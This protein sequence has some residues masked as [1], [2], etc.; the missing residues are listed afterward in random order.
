[1]RKRI[2]FIESGLTETEQKIVEQG[3][4]QLSETKGAPEYKKQNLKWVLYDDRILQGALT[5]ST[6][7]D[8]LY[9]D[10]LWVSEAERGQGLGKALLDEAERFATEN[11]LSG[12]WLWTQSWQA[13]EFYKKQGFLEFARFENFPKG[14][15]RIGLRK[16][17]NGD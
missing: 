9:I 13:E 8:W 10:E 16:E 15:Q 12:L 14:H 6:L 2:K 1:M 17:L 4:T 11:K 5:A 7:W 3:F